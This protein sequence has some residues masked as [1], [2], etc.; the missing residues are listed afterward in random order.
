[1][2][3]ELEKVFE[4]CGCGLIEVYPDTFLKVLGKPREPLVKITGVLGHV[5]PLIIFCVL[6]RS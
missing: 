5:I 2:N 6:F 3:D 1:M 4:G